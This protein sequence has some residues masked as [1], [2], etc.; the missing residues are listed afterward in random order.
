MVLKDGVTNFN[1]D[2]ANTNNFKSFLYKPELLGNTEADRADGIS[3]NTR[4][5][6]QLK[7]LSNFW[8]SLEMPLIDCKVELKLKWTNHCVSSTAGADNEKAKYNIT[9]T[10]KDTKLCL[11]SHFISK[12]QSKTLKTS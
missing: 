2:F 4:I 12:R 11:C 8:R 6:V 9:F 3:K 1:N 7:Y 10:I 5:I